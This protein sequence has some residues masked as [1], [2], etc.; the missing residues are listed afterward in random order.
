MNEQLHFEIQ[1]YKSYQ[2]SLLESKKPIIPHKSMNLI[3]TQKFR[4]DPDESEVGHSLD[5][6]D[7]VKLSNYK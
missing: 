4:Y 7:Y 2:S 5:I 1:D 3:T 6:E